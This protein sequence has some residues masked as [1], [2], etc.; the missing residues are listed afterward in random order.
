MALWDHN[1][2]KIF[3]IDYME[4]KLDGVINGKVCDIPPTSMHSNT[5]QHLK[6]FEFLAV[7][8]DSKSINRWDIMT[9]KLLGSVNTKDKHGIANFVVRAPFSL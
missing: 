2:R 5:W 8:E 4:G 1:T 7:S 3:L 6:G 9:G